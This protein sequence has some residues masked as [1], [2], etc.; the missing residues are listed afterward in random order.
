MSCVLTPN[1][2]RY[3]SGLG[4]ISAGHV[5]T[6]PSGCG[7]VINPIIAPKWGIFFFSIFFLGTHEKV[8]RLI[9][10]M[11]MRLNSEPNPV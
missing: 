2:V 10:W 4:L 5:D 11:Q 6:F 8:H 1:T 3:S 7:D 9:P